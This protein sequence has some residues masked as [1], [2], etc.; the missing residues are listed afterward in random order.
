MDATR[1]EV[2]R[3]APGLPAR[4]AQTHEADVV[5]VGS[6]AA[7]LMAALHAARSS[8]AQ[9]ALIA[10]AS[11]ME[12]N[13][14]HA[15]GGIAVAIGHDD[16]P[17]LQAA[18]TL[19]VT[20][21]L[22]DE[23]A[24]RVLTEEGPARLQELLEL[25]LPLDRED[26]ELALGLEAGHSRRRIVHVG[27]ATGRAL[28]QT[29][30][31][32]VA[33]LLNVRWYTGFHAAALA[34]AEDVC[35]GLWALAPDGA[36]HL[37]HAG[38]TILATGG[39]G[40][41]FA[42]TSNP[43]GALG[44]GIALAYRAG[45]TVADLEF[46]QFHPTV[47]PTPEG[48]FLI[49]EAVRGEGAYLLSSRGRF[50][51]QY[52]ARAE[53][54]PRDV[55]AR[56][57]HWEMVRTNAPH[58]WLD[59][60]HLGESCLSHRFPT[61]YQRCQEIGIDPAHELIPVAPAAH[62]MMGGVRTDLWGATDVSGLYACGECACTGVHGANR[63]ASNSLLECLVFGARAAAAAMERTSVTPL[64]EPEPPLAEDERVAIWP[65]GGLPAVRARL[66]ADVGLAR[67]GIHL[68]KAI[69]WLDALQAPTAPSPASSQFLTREHVLRVARLMARAA[70]L[71]A[72][73]RGAHYRTDYPEPDAR[74]RAHL[75]WRN[76]AKASLAYPLHHHLGG[77]PTLRL[78]SGQA[79]NFQPFGL[80]VLD[81]RPGS[82]SANASARPSGRS[83]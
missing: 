72:E 69:E 34:L 49:S 45:A 5:I 17:A 54:A 74:W 21:G 68:L 29:L 9:V 79:S 16:A 3:Y 38:T 71:R 48:A 36:L 66:M 33:A 19:A 22:A 53:L 61:I 43:P 10:K 2:S 70:W 58:V 39:A 82:A 35:V 46:V 76:G 14:A 28:A 20:G 81:D 24:V 77:P 13:T 75:L 6:G 40:A 63:L 15:Q 51:P 67:E 83:L 23:E 62:Y 27:D 65:E 18:D 80:P 41:L 55:V 52:D 44:E 30:A 8:G 25:G 4:P 12:S 64:L 1:L 37:F 56:A 7:G 32:A 31:G 42:R 73:S 47:M 57:I 60:R 26:G 59:V 78:R 11:P 50:M